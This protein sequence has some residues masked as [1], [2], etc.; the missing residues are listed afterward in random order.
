MKRTI[1]T[2]GLWIVPLML[3]A[4]A[5]CHASATT[6][7]PAGGALRAA[8]PA[9]AGP[10]VRVTAA[11][12]VRK[13]LRRVTVQPGRIEAFE[14]TPLFAKLPAFVAKVHRDIGDRVEAAQPLVDL[15]IPELEDDAR[16]KEASLVQAGA[17]VEQAAAALRAADAAVETAE[18]GVREAAAGMIRARGKYERWKSEHRRMAELAAGGSVDR[19]LVD[20]TQDELSAAE[21]ALAE[22]QAKVASAEAALAQ[23]KAN[24]QKA[25][26]D[27]AAARAKLKVAE[28]D[29][30]RDRSLLQYA[31]IRMPYTGIV[32]E[33]NVN[34]GDFVQPAGAATAK[35]LM[36]V[37]RYDLVRVFV[38]V[39]EMDA[40]LVEQGAKG[41]ILVQAL[42][43][44]KI[45][46]TVTRTS[47]ALGPNR[48]LRTELDVPNPDGLLRPGMYAT[49]EILLTER[50]QVIALALAAIVRSDKQAF[51]YCVDRGQIARRPLVLG[52]A[53]AEEAE[54]VSGLSGEEEVVQSQVAS[55]R[56]G[57]AVEVA[58]PAER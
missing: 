23:G 13:T 36:A 55:L 24:V 35:P 42:P 26:A 1:V 8:D 48:T 17:G 9:A 11:K 52:L 31:Q 45:E 43:G 5:G 34:R 22:G 44:R 38:D 2:V 37:A 14:Q 3:A 30:A 25:K 51:C 41:S 40:P 53:T 29:L 20:E 10:A 27:L 32:T 28:A 18:A 49:A 50:P 54:V 39:P 12:P 33:R 47:W 15:S 58:P 46:G 7:E 16:Q 57:Q 56:E 6:A 19:K 21:A 4:I